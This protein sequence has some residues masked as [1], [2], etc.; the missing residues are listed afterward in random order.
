MNRFLPVVLA[1][2]V[3]VAALPYSLAF[4]KKARVGQLEQKQFFRNDLYISSSNVQVDAAELR[5]RAVPEEHAVEAPLV[6]QHLAKPGATRAP[7]GTDRQGT[8]CT[9]RSTRHDRRRN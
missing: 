6:R 1:V 8:R 9:A 2:I 5:Q 4:E 3:A 7:G